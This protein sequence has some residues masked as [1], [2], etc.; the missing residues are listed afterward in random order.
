M[1]DKPG[2]PRLQPWGAVNIDDAIKILLRIQEAGKGS[3][4]LQFMEI[5]DGIT[6]AHDVGIIEAE[7]YD[8]ER[9]WIYSTAR[10]KPEWI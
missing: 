3:L 1:A 8:G 6:Y 5:D 2:I 10:H 7:E 4:P 9:I